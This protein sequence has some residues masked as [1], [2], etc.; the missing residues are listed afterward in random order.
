[1]CHRGVTIL[2]PVACCAP[3]PT[4]GAVVPTGLATHQCGQ[5]QPGS[6]KVAL[7]SAGLATLPM[8]E[9]LFPAFMSL[10]VMGLAIYAA[11]PAAG[12]LLG[13]IVLAGAFAAVRLW[14]K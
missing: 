7:S 14:R 3:C 1:V 4:C 8:L 11:G 12:M 13:A 6:S 2:H 10:M 5:K 9:G